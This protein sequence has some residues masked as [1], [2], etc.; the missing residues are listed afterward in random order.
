M[1]A[2]TEALPSEEIDLR[3]K[4]DAE[5]GDLFQYLQGKQR[6]QREAIHL[7]RLGLMCLTGG[8]GTAAVAPMATPPVVAAKPRASRS[9][10]ATNTP[11]KSADRQ[12]EEAG[13]D[14]LSVLSEFKADFFAAPPSQ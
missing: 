2:N 9:S 10:S 4:L 6:K 13:L 14:G 3:L 8:L 7:M 12:P 11:A 1:S 5:L